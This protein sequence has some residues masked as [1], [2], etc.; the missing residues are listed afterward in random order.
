MTKEEAAKE[1]G[2]SV[3]ALER[4]VK[5][6][7]LPVTYTKGKRGRQA[8]YDPVE[9]GKLKKELQGEKMAIVTLGEK[10]ALT[11]DEA[12]ILSGFPR[13]FIERAIEQGR[14]KKIENRI[15]R[16]DLELFVSSLSDE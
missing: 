7:K 5:M 1:L 9:V 16:Q 4:Y 15:R 11:L 12:V 14:L 3:R 8:V 13:A 2:I 6:G 10:L